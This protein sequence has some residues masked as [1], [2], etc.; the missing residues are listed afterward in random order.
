MAGMRSCSEYG[1]AGS[2]LKDCSYPQEGRVKS[3]RQ[4]AI[5]LFLLYLDVD[6][7]LVG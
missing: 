3:E 1:F 5:F 2:E 6:S 4:E 7:E